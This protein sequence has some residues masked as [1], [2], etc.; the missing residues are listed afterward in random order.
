ML[1]VAFFMEECPYTY[2]SR[3]TRALPTASAYYNQKMSSQVTDENCRS[4][5]KFTENIQHIL[6]GC[7]AL[8]QTKYLQ[9]HNN[10]LKILFIKVLRSLNLISKVESW[11]S[12]A[13]PEPVYDN[14][15]AT[16]YWD[17]ALY[18]DTT[19]VKANRIHVTI[20]DELNKKVVVIEMSCMAGIKRGERH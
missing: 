12:I 20:I 10:A 2:R 19:L 13:E 18:A 15:R 7:S 3:N 17:V 11:F 6:S 8:A 5:G 1:C 4:C 9:R 16:A 14:E